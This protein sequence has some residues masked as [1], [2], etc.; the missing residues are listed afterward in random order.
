MA[1]AT[2][3]VTH[4]PGPWKIIDLPNADSIGVVPVKRP[5]GVKSRN[6]DDIASVSKSSEHYDARSNA[7]LIAAAPDLLAAL[8]LAEWGAES[9]RYVP[10]CPCCESFRSE[11]HEADC[12]LAGAIAKAEGK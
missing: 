3:R 2:E 7:R 9:P 8:K 11:G 6:V 5:A 1:T 10:S 12:V 4:T